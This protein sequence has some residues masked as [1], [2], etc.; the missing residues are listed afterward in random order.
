ML[1]VPTRTD[2]PQASGARQLQVPRASVLAARAHAPLPG[3]KAFHAG[4]A[5][6]R[7]SALR[8]SVASGRWSN[9]MSRHSLSV[10]SAAATEVQE[11][12]YEYKA[13]VCASACAGQ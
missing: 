11:E 9:Q 4:L 12:T 10:N 7:G 13:E 6:F 3:S 8:S 2:A 1:L 5:N